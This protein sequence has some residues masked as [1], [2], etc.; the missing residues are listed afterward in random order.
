MVDLSNLKNPVLRYRTYKKQRGMSMLRDWIDCRIVELGWSHE[1]LAD[2]LGLTRSA[3]TYLINVKSNITFANVLQLLI[4]AL[5]DDPELKGK[6]IYRCLKNRDDAEYFHLASAVDEDAIKT[7]QSREF[8]QHYSEK[9]RQV[10]GN[11]VVVTPMEL[12]AET[13]RR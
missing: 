12:I 10:A 6:I 7:L 4:A 13:T 11:G 2:R 8:F 9:T 3:V 1:A 5:N